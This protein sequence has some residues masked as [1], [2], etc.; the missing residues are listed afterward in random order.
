[1]A[2]GTAQV[3]EEKEKE[4]GQP[5]TQMRNLSLQAGGHGGN[6]SKRSLR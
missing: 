6:P 5:E 4:R 3:E 1:M 2:T